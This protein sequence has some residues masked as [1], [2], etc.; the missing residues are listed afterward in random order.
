MRCWTVYNLDGEGK[1]QT[2]IFVFIFVCGV[3]GGS[4]WEY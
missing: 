1:Y 2:H 4:D 3:A